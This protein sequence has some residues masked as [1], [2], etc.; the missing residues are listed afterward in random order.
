M[1]V[2][3]NLNNMLNKMHTFKVMAVNIEIKYYAVL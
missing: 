3:K 2:C 1:F